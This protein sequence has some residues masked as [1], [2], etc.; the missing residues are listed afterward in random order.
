MSDKGKLPAF[1]V[2]STSHAEFGLAGLCIRDEFAARA[3]QGLL[4]Q[5]VTQECE[6]GARDLEPYYLLQNDDDL[7]AARAYRIADAMIAESEKKP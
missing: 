7:L 6:N 1:P 4:A 3:M 2:E 5:H